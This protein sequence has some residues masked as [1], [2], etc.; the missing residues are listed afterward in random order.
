M[1]DWFENFYGGLYEEI[2]PHRFD[3]EES[4]QHAGTVESLLGIQPGDSVLDIPCGMGRVA[5]PLAKMG[6]RVTGL[7]FHKGYIRTARARAKAEG[8]DVN[9]ICDDMRSITFDAEF[10][11]AFNWFGSFGYFSDEEN[12]DFLKKALKAIK[13]G[14]RFLV[15]GLNKSWYLVHL[16]ER[17]EKKVGEVTVRM[18]KSFDADAS[19]DRSTWSFMRGG[20]TERHR[21]AIR[22]FNGAELRELLEQAGFCDVCLCGWPSLAELDESSPRLIA[23]ASRPRG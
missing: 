16:P 21:L 18:R 20:R 19:R 7:D 4:E 3:D 17:I 8:L 6:L 1:P 5:L 12:F 13:P 14:A 2:L 23:V 11:G 22:I 10:D 15:E 9:F